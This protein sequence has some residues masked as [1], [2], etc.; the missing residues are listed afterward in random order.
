MRN[1]QIAG[2]VGS[3]SG[4]NDEDDNDELSHQTSETHH[5]LLKTFTRSMPRPVT[6]TLL[7]FVC[8]R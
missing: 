6:P 5:Q 4:A 7:P 3:G 8:V 1:T 2:D